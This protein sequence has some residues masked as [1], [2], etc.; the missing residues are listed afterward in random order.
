[1]KTNNNFLIVFMAITSIIINNVEA[2]VHIGGL[3]EYVDYASIN[4]SNT[5][6]NNPY[7]DFEGSPFLNSDFDIG[8]I[9]LKNRKIY[10]GLLRYDIYADQ[11]EFKTADGNIYAVKNPE[12][13]G[14][15]TINSSHFICFNKIEENSLEGI[16][17]VLADGE[18]LLIEKHQVELKDPI[19]AKPYVEAKPA[20]FSTKKSKYFIL[21]LE[22]R[23]IEI[24]T[25]K[26]LIALDTKKHDELKSYIKKN[27]IKISR[28]EDLI[29][30]VNFINE[31]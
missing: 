29:S 24:K 4:I 11:I 13:L 25:K 20:S 15:I 31:I 7:A 19:A 28:K 8:Q 1:M 6:F 10:E 2:Q 18:Y 16:Y 14:E 26:D 30:F 9:K 3:Q 21:N 12:V 5:S 27:K 22:G 17:E 23:F